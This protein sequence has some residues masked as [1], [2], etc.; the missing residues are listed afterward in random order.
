MR[1]GLSG[2]FHL[3]PGN[4]IMTS[5]LA[6]EVL[7]AAG[8][9]GNVRVFNLPGKCSQTMLDASKASCIL[10]WKPEVLLEDGL[11]DTLE[12]IR[13]NTQNMKRRGSQ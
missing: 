5:E 12:H 4:Y 1:N 8:S 7:K 3:A 2:I 9:L 10:G 6:D 13:L 11:R